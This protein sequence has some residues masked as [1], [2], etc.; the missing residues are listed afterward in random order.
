MPAWPVFT[1][2]NPQYLEMDVSSAV[3]SGLKSK[4]CK[5]QGD[6]ILDSFGK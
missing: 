1:A 3:K 2:A 6:V 5:F 4:E